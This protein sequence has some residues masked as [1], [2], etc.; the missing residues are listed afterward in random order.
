MSCLTV[1]Y[2]KK[3]LV[4]LPESTSFLFV[5]FGPSLA[6]SL[7]SIFNSKIILHFEIYISL[8]KDFKMAFARL[9][10]CFYCIV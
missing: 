10:F 4:S 1:T 5:L 3:C 7:Y 2:Q 9:Y 6:N 8:M